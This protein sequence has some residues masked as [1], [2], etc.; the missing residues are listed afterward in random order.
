MSLED[1][2]HDWRSEM[3][4]SLPPAEIDR[5]LGVVQERYAVLERQVHN[6]DVREILAAVLVVFLFAP[7]LWPVY[8]QSLVAFLGVALIICGA[9]LIVYVFLT[10]RKPE[11]ASFHT[12]VLEC[13]RNRRAWLDGQISLLRSVVWWYVGPIGVGLLLFH[14][15]LARGSLIVFSVQ[16]AIVLAVCTGVVL[17]NRWSVRKALLP[18]RDEVSRLIESLERENPE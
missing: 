5:L 17:L 14:W 9:A 1:L 18:V 10:S 13:A 7:S 8:R 11:P 15:G 16:A 6:R 4:R 12:A 3:D 2:K